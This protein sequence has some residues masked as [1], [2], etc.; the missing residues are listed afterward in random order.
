MSAMNPESFQ[1]SGSKLMRLAGTC[2]VMSGC[3][4][5]DQ[6]PGRA[7]LSLVEGNRGIEIYD[8]GMASHVTVPVKQVYVRDLAGLTDENLGSLPFELQ[9]LLKGPRQQ[10]SLLLHD[11]DFREKDENGDTVVHYRVGMRLDDSG[12]SPVPPAPFVQFVLEEGIVANEVTPDSNPNLAIC[13]GCDLVYPA[14]AHRLNEETGETEAYHMVSVMGGDFS[15]CSYEPYINGERVWDPVYEN[16]A[17]VSWQLD[18]S[19]GAGSVPHNTPNGAMAYST[20]MEHDETFTTCG[21]EDNVGYH[22]SFAMER[23]NTEEELCIPDSE[24]HTWESSLSLGNNSLDVLFSPPEGDMTTAEGDGVEALTTGYH[25]VFSNNEM[26]ECARSRFLFAGDAME[27]LSVYDPGTPSSGNDMHCLRPIQNH[28]GDIMGIRFEADSTLGWPL[29]NEWYAQFANLSTGQVL[30]NVTSN[31]TLPETGTDFCGNVAYISAVNESGVKV[32][33]EVYPEDN[34]PAECDLRGEIVDTGD[35]GDTG[36][37]VDTADTD[38]TGDIVD[39]SDTDNV[40]DTADTGKTNDDEGCDCGSSHLNG[41]G[42]SPL[43]L[44]F[45]AL[46]RRKLYRI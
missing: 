33:Y 37:I 4:V 28:D 12:S 9:E 24:T 44:G 5:P 38:D 17:I 23:G 27:Q 30:L 3:G 7:P 8:V 41:A 21:R 34:P 13:D 26:L 20:Y 32:L 46:I 29:D 15:E 36:E 22:G 14:V 10:V 45:A 18:R 16:C 6:G 2:L 19:E 1:M 35:T 40:V 43:L 25:N 42:L 31:R 39:T 11:G